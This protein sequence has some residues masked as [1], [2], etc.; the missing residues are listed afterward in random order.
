M[1]NN[2]I[3]LYRND[4]AGGAGGGGGA[5]AGAGSG[6]GSGDGGAA[7]AGAAGSAGAGAGA[8]AQGGQGGSGAQDW[9]GSI[10]PTIKDNPSL[11]K[12]KDPGALAKSYLEL[13]KK[14]GA[15]GIAIPGKDAKADDF[16][17]VMDQLGRPKDASEYKLPDVKLPDGLPKNEA[18]ENGFKSLAHKAGLLPF[19]VEGLYKWYAESQVAEYNQ[20]VKERTDARQAAEASLRKEWGKAYD[21]NIAM[22]DRI[23]KQFADDDFKTFMDESGLGNDP[24]FHKFMANVSKNFSPDSIGGDRGLTTKTPDEAVREINRIR[25]DKEHPLFEAYRNRQHPDHD[26]AVKMMTDLHEQAY[27]ED[28]KG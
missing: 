1:L 25:V 13:E 4:D 11:S 19:Q 26:H 15:K 21:A 16:V 5:G 12:F 10:D 20:L 27:P 8:G 3:R 17:A 14:I 2:F 28:K 9:R 6:A 23:W 18:L 22:N 24:R 7:G